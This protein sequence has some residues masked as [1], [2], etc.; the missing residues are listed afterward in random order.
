MDICYNGIQTDFHLIKSRLKHWFLTKYLFSSKMGDYLG[1]ESTLGQQRT[2]YQTKPSFI[3]NNS[4][5]SVG[6]SYLS[7]R[8]IDSSWE[9]GSI[10][11]DSCLTTHHV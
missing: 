8:I 3:N 9:K 4:I 2:E 5:I 1:T 7:Q 10:R 11:L 6:E